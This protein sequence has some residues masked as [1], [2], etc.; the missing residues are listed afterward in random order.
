M[1]AISIV[2]IIAVIAVIIFKKK[3]SGNLDAKVDK[4]AKEAFTAFIKTQIRVYTLLEDQY[5]DYYQDILE[6]HDVSIDMMDAMMKEV[7]SLKAYF[8]AFTEKLCEVAEGNCVFIN[9]KEKLAAFLDQHDSLEQSEII[10]KDIMNTLLPLA[11]FMKVYSTLYCNYALNFEVL[12][13][14]RE[15]YEALKEDENLLQHQE[16][17]DCCKKAMWAKYSE[18]IEVLWES[19]AQ[20]HPDL[21]TEHNRGMFMHIASNHHDAQEIWENAWYDNLRKIGD[22]YHDM[23]FDLFLFFKEIEETYCPFSEKQEN[24]LLGFALSP[25]NPALILE[26][27]QLNADECQRIHDLYA[28]GKMKGYYSRAVEQGILN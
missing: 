28:S 26:E 19:F 7:E 24:W 10:T 5:A 17:S 6:K 4:M 9:T 2:A 16:Y 23:I 21:N 15:L 14:N 20:K 3:K 22:K 12:T 18:V 11:G 8:K 25:W 1:E 13:L 27:K